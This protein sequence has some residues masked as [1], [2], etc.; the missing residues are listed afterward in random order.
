MSRASSFRPPVPMGSDKPGSGHRAGITVR[1][2]ERSHPGRRGREVIPR[3]LSSFCPL[4]NCRFRAERVGI[5]C[6]N[7]LCETVIW[8]SEGC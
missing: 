6:L 3:D 7:C 8:L 1:A 5:L 2:M 4:G